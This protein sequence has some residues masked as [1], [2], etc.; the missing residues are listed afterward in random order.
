MQYYAVQKPINSHLC[1]IVYYDTAKVL[2]YFHTT[3][4]FGQ[5]FSKNAIILRTIYSQPI[6][7]YYELI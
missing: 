5:L 2:H 1:V 7:L 3:K 6:H 4:F